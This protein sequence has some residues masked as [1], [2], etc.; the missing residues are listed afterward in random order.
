MSLFALGINHHTADVA[1]RECFAFTSG[2]T[3]LI[4]RDLFE[5]RAVNEAVVLSTCNRTEVYAVTQCHHAVKEWLRRNQ[6]VKKPALLDKLYE[7]HGSSMI[8]HLMAVASGLDSMIVGEPQILGQLKQAYHTAVKHGTIGKQFQQLFPAVFET[9]KLVRTETGIGCH[10]VTLAY[11][12]VQLAKTIFPHIED[13]VVLLLGSGETIEL[14]ADYLRQQG[15]NRLL[16]ANRTVSR[17]HQLARR[18]H[19]T[20]MS[21]DK[22]N[23]V[24]PEVD[25][26]ISATTSSQ[27]MLRASAVEKTLQQRGDRPLFIADLGVPR[28]VEASVAELEGVSLQTIDGLQQI[29]NQNQN[30]RVLAM[31]KARAIIEMQATHYLRLLR[32]REA[33]QT[34]RCYRHKMENWRD[35]VLEKSLKKLDQQDDAAQVMRELA[36]QLTKKFMHSPTL[37]LR[38]ACYAEETEL[39]DLIRDIYE[40]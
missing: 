3:P 34:I 14:I 23:D 13:R 17:A 35:S 9:A 36:T 2:E 5:H 15:V 7:H 27:P 31:D 19:G 33:S 12:V 32:V 6:S 8:K 25:V 10:A 29:V 38:E 4:V 22:V 24:L 40:L 1:E 37:K 28:N 30:S 11:A 16:V 20:P 39:L 26:V 18:Y 21:L